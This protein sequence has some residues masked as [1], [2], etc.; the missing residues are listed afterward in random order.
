MHIQEIAPD[1]YGLVGEMYASNSTAIVSGDEA[2]LVDA[3]AGRRDA[4][5]LRSF[6]ESELGKRVRFIICT[7]FFSDH[8]AAL[9]L[10]PNA[11][12]I[13]HQNYTQTFDA[14]RFSTQ[15]EKANFAEPNILIS[16]GIRMRWGRYEL[17]IFHNPGHTMSTLNV[18]IPGADLLLVGDNIVGN[19]VYF[20]YSSPQ[21]Q[22]QALQRLRW[23]ARTR[24]IEGHGGVLGG[25][26]VD[27]AL[28]YLKS[29]EMEVSLAR[30]SDRPD[31]SILEIELDKCMRPGVRG[32]DYERVY[33]ERNLQVTIERGLFTQAAATG[34]TTPA[35]N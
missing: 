23:R 21:L 9:K 34:S 25:D 32:T 29:L 33:H 22:R 7:H 4:E 3:M 16:D 8:L 19:M 28:H 31:D 14:E 5:Q 30:L 11:S 27:N 6:V 18:D 10:F 12:I 13:A 1:L 26:T 15:E 2:L 24:I 17:D 35:I 20:Y